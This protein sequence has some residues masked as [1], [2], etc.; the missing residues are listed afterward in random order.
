MDESKANQFNNI[1]LGSIYTQQLLREVGSLKELILS[2]IKRID[3]ST[4]SVQSDLVRISPNIEKGISGLKELHEKQIE[5]LQVLVDQ[6]FLGIE[7]QFKERDLRFDERL[8]EARLA[9]DSSL[10]YAEKAVSK[11]EGGTTKQIDQ[12]AT[13]ILTVNKTLDHVP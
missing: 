10:L 7:S 6:K 11:S 1:D 4:E 12:Q 9:V 3:K 2:E 8:K 5:C 13:A